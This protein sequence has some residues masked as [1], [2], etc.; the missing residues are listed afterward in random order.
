[1]G[2]ANTISCV[3]LLVFLSILISIASFRIPSVLSSSK[4]VKKLNA[5]HDVRK[6][7]LHL[8]AI[9][10][11]K[12]QQDEEQQIEVENKQYKDDLI[13]TGGWVGAALGFAGI[14]GAT[15]GTD[16]A[17]EF[18]S[19]YALEQSLSVDNLFVFLLLFDYFKVDKSGQDK[20]LGYGLWS[21]V[22][23]RGLFI[24]LGTVALTNF[25]QVLLL[26]AFVLYYSSYKILFTG[27][28]DEEEEDMSDNFI[29]NFSKKYL[30]MTDKADGD[31]FFT[32]SNG[33]KLATPLLLCLICIE[34][35]DIVF[36]FDSVPAVFGVTK[37]P[38]IV[39]TSNIFAIAGLRSLFSVLSNAIS[40]LEYLEKAV[41]LVLALIAVK[42]TGETFDYEL[43]TPIQSLVIVLGLLGGGVGLSILKNN[44]DAAIVATTSE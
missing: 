33:E 2:I 25:H 18:I 24:G 41:G 15:K 21:A 34:L 5:T 42:I 36:A 32:V 26:F 3:R 28:D 35:S 19:G 39:F 31:N 4:S 20:I 1:M 12:Q 40:Q 6:N 29:V 27:N 13:R 14:I 16:S 38:L 44:K 23:L 22:I 9:K 10:N 7:A 11:L 8:Q 30:K 43:L 17:I 37:D